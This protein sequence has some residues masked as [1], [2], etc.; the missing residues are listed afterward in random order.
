MGMRLRKLHITLKRHDQYGGKPVWNEEL[1]ASLRQ[2]H[3]TEEFQVVV[4]WAV[5][6]VP[7][8]NFRLTHIDG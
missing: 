8:E 6:Q 4:N 2:V 1:I 7:W 3:A 5:A